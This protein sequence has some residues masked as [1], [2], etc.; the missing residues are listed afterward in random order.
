[1]G[2]VVYQRLKKN[3][4]APNIAD[5]A[6]LLE[7]G[8]S[9]PERGGAVPL[10]ATGGIS[11]P[12]VPVLAIW[13]TLRLAPGSSVG[14]IRKKTLFQ[15]S[16]ITHWSR[17]FIDCQTRMIT[18]EDPLRELLFYEDRGFSDTLNVL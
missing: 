16:R 13:R 1:M 4:N 17:E 12:F 8:V 6:S 15:F 9:A 18:G 3:R 7:R 14:R 11:H 10:L 5:Q 2:H